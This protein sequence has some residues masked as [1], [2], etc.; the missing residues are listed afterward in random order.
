MDKWKFVDS[1][2]GEAAYNMALDEALFRSF[3]PG[4][5]R[6]VFR[7]YR[8]IKPAISLGRFQT[9]EV[10]NLEKCKK[11]NL[12]VVK[13][14]TGGSGL[15][16]SQAELTYSL[17]CA[18]SFINSASI[19]ES[20][21]KITYFLIKAY[22]HLGL[23]AQFAKDA[24]LSAPC[25]NRRAG[26]SAEPSSASAS[27]PGVNKRADF[28]FSDWQ[29]YDILIRGRKIGGNAQ[30]RRRGVIFQHGSIPFELP[31]N[32]EGYFLKKEN[33]KSRYLSLS[34]LGVTDFYKF[35]NVL[36]DSFESSYGINFA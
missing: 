2:F 17:V 20:Y 10:L 29:E 35:K 12:V 25:V 18:S 9:D 4:S 13:R 23:E 11:D 8:W 14:I 26:T 31:D 5:S 30:R 28:C 24:V 27:A 7:L 33:A 32:L 34:E 21:Q 1:G 16:H 22:R 19:K 15:Y 36:I 3:S 6:P